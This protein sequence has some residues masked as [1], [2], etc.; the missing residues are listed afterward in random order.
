MHDDKTIDVVNYLFERLIAINPA[1][2]QAWPTEQEFKATKKEWVLAFIDAKI[3]KIEQLKRGLSKVRVDPS[4]FIPSPGAFIAHCK[5]TAEDI[6]APNVRDAYD[7][8]ILHDPESRH[9]EQ[10]TPWSHACVKYA[11]EK[12]DPFFL[13][14]KPFRE[15]FERFE[16]NYQIALDLFSE[17]KIMHQIEN[18][19]TTAAYQEYVGR[20][21]S[22]I[23]IKILPRDTEILSFEDWCAK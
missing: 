23:K 6:G 19:K 17:N 9:R 22:D 18:H 8:A 21:K 10:V 7:Q 5:L 20:L 2:R 13:R 14:T 3:N 12:S 1:F 4:P 11:Y 15:S 16:E